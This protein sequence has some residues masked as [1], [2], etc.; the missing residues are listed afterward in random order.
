VFIGLK[1][2]V[3]IGVLGPHLNPSGLGTILYIM[4]Q[5]EWIKNIVIH[6]N[7]SIIITPLT[8]KCFNAEFRNGS[9]PMKTEYS[10]I[11]LLNNL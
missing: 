8:R 5:N 6:V 10:L 7:Y 1:P 3:R 9:K 2:N 4:S 11:V